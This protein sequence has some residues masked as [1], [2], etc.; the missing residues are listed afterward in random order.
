L[1]QMRSRVFGGHSA[2]VTTLINE[3]DLVPRIQGDDW[4]GWIVSFLFTLYVGV[5]S[6]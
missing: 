3:S 2:E 6:P 4:F 5:P 1:A